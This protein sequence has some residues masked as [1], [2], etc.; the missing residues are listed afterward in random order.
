MAAF[1]PASSLVGPGELSLLVESPAGVSLHVQVDRNPFLI[2]RLGECNLTLRDSRI[3]RRHARILLSD[4]AY[5]I[6]DLQSRHGLAVNGAR[7]VRHGLVVGDRIEF[8]VRDSFRITVCKG[9]NPKALLLKKVSNLSAGPSRT[10]ALGRLSAMLE[11]ARSME[12]SDGVDEVF[13]AV[14]EAAL[15]IAG[16]DRAFLLLREE[17]G[18]LEVKVGRDASGGTRGP[19]DLKFPLGLIE[20]A[21]DERPDLFA[22]TLADSAGSVALDASASSELELRSTLCVPILRMRIGQ[23]H[24]TSL[25][26][27]RANTLGAI[28][29][30]TGEPGTRLAEGNQALLQAL[31]IEI[32]TV[33]ENARLI[34]QEREKRR[35]EHELQVARSIQRALLPSALPDAGWLVAKGHCEARA[36]LGG[37]Y[38]DLMQ[39]APGKWAAVVADVSGK[40]VAASIL[41]SLLQGAFF[42]GSGPDVSLAGTLG[43]IN[44]YICERSRQTRFATVFALILGDDG[45]MR[46]S[47]A[48]HCPAVLLRSSGD[49]EWLRSNSRPVGLFDDVVFSEDASLLQPG[50]KLVVY[51]DG[52]TELRNAA[53]EQF[54]ESRL[55]TAVADLARLGASQLFDALLERVREFAGDEPRTDDLTLLVLGF[56][57]TP[58]AASVDARPGPRSPP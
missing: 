52:I 14:V 49:C 10:G 26:S 20:R 33:I 35:L 16:A 7:A 19:A 15:T 42:L 23:D 2:G 37:D 8:G 38:Y 53:G 6:E 1:G 22:I 13:E 32:S 21:L 46:W 9:G 58:D 40:G 56:E 5:S 29:M 27:S 18:E 3:S 41:A 17:G 39:V 51:S 48:G 43:R 12:S 24:E 45:T 30:D 57:G 11:V 47:N 25:I 55:G 50:D 28:Y 4:G 31:A 54:G 34:E 36:Q 44:R